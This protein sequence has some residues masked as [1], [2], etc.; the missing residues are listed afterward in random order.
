[1]E[2][3]AS[4]MIIIGLTGGVGCGKSTVGNKMKE[5]FSVKLQM[6]D[7]IG[8]LAMEEGTRCYAEICRIFGKDMIAENGQ[9]RRDKL[10]EVVFTNLEKLE[11]L[12]GLI[13]PWVIE[14]LKTDIERERK[15]KRFQFYVIESAILLE[16]NLDRL[17]D[18][19]WYVNT[20]KDIRRKRLQD[21]RGYSDEKIDAIMAQQKDSAW[22]QEHCQ[23]DIRNNA[24]LEETM[25]Q[26]KKQL[27]ILGNQYEM[28][29]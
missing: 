24:I 15:E 6:T 29:E 20:D 23:V 7:Q 8:H 19:V 27:Q 13:H 11:I 25:E 26:V 28:E 10:A 22:I 12:N 4:A 5:I 17:C 21:S 1:M 3:S 18:V 2:V 16:T 9:I 14:Y